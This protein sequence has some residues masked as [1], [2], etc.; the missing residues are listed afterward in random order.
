M[1]FVP[2]FEAPLENALTVVGRLWRF[3][4]GSK[5]NVGY[6]IIFDQQ[7]RRTCMVTSRE[8]LLGNY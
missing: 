6:A 1:F 7:T 5:L 2:S 8:T 4:D 3:W